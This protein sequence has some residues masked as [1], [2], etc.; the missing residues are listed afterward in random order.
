MDFSRALAVFLCVILA[1]LAFVTQN[2]L[3]GRGM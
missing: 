3:A 1:S 2:A